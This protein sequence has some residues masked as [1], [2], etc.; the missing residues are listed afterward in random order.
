MDCCVMMG[1]V[2]IRA[3]EL[4]VLGLTWVA[5]DSNPKQKPPHAG[6]FN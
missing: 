1:L 6:G 5:W 4:E 3:A 2:V